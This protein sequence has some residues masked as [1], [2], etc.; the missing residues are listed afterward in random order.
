M[1]F[2]DLLIYA[3]ATFRV[4]LM[5]SAED[6]PAFIFRKIRRMPPPKSATHKGISC[7]LCCSVYAAA[8][9]ATAFAFREQFPW[10]QMWLI[11]PLAFSG[12]AV[13]LHMQ[14]TKDL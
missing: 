10:V 6:G 2:L 9:A 11:Y 14:F 12:A 1:T 13:C 3:L 5:V 8:L 7:T 4:A